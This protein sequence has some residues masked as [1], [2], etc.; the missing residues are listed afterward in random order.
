MHYNKK[1]FN[2]FYGSLIST[3]GTCLP[4]KLNAGALPRFESGTEETPVKIFSLT[5]L[6]YD[7]QT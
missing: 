2:I 7:W 6:R 3:G 1:Y 5:Y 4:P